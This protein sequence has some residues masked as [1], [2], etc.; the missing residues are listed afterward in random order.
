MSKRINV[1]IHVVAD[2]APSLEAITMLTQT[3]MSQCREMNKSMIELKKP[4]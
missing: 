1:K 2:N 3:F 4:A